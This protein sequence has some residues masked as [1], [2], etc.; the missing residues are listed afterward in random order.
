[1]YQEVERLEESEELENHLEEELLAQQL[2]AVRERERQQP[3]LRRS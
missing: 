2:D 3:S 1:M